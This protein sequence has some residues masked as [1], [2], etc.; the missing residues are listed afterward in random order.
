M[1]LLPIQLI[2]LAILIL[3][4]SIGCAG[5]SS[6]PVTPD[7]TVS[8]ATTSP[9]P[10]N[11]Y[12]WGYWDVSIDPDT[13]QA[14]V[15][16]ARTTDFH[17][18]AVKLLEVWPCKDC[19]S[20][21]N[22]HLIEPHKLSVDVTLRHPYANNLNLTA[23]DVRGI[24][25][26]DADY[27]YFYEFGWGREV[28][29]LTNADG[30]CY[31]F[32]MPINDWLPD[33]LNYYPGD[34]ANSDDLSSE[35]NPFIAYGRSAPRRMFLPGTQETRTME[36][37]FPSAPFEFGY[38]VD[39]CWAPPGKQV[40]DPEVDFPPEANC[41]EPYRIFVR[42][43]EGLDE[44]EQSSAK[45]QVKAYD[46]QGP[47]TISFCD[48]DCDDVSNLIPGT[49]SV[50]LPDDSV[51]FTGSITN[52]MGAEVG[53]YPLMVRVV[54]HNADPNLDKRA[55]FQIVP[56]E[57]HPM[58]Q[59]PPI[60][61]GDA[62]P[63]LRTVGDEIEFFDDGSY[64]P[65]GGSITLWEWD[66]END[67][68]YD[69]E[70]EDIFHAYDTPGEY[71]VM[72][73][74]TDDDGLST[75]LDEPIAITVKT[76]I[77]WVRTWPAYA[78]WDVD[79]DGE[80]NVYVAGYW[81]GASVDFD[82][83]PDEDIHSEPGDFTAFLVKYGKTGIYQ[84]GKS[85]G[86]V[87]YYAQVGADR[88]TVDS[89]GNVFVGG[90]FNYQVDFDPGPGEDIHN[91]NGFLDAYISK[92]NADGDYQWVRILSGDNHDSVH[93]LF[94]DSDGS[95]YVC[96]NFWGQI[97]LDP[98]PGEDI[99]VSNGGTDVYLLKLDSDGSVEWARS[100]GSDVEDPSNPSDS[101]NRISADDSGHVF[102]TGFYA[103]SCDFDP[104]PGEDIHATND[105]HNNYGDAFLSAFDSDGNFMWA[106]TWGGIKGDSS[107]G[108]AV[109][110]DGSIYTTGFFRYTVD[111][112]P[113][114]G[115]DEHTSVEYTDS[116]LSRFSSGGDFFWAG[117]WEG[118]KHE[119]GTALAS[120]GN[121]GI[122]VTGT[123][124]VTTDF[125]PGPGVEE[126]TPASGYSPDMF[127]SKFNTD[128]EFQWVNVW[129]GNGTGDFDQAYGVTC[130]PG[131]EPYVTGTH[132]GTCDFDPGP[133]V[134]ERTVSHALE[135]FLLRFAPD[136]S[137]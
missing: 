9:T 53:I 121:G 124:Y 86:S 49:T 131:G 42:I 134:D 1:R 48:L 98:G 73:R 94:P 85:W 60:A 76:G 135:A 63:K 90:A 110:S 92:F 35:L 66:F 91:S 40:V 41:N 51:L 99:R 19:L 30:Y 46:H 29:R 5:G 39:A 33:I 97:D 6:N 59:Y 103:G 105:D 62:Y 25:I 129:G 79:T 120:D 45:I 65:D 20:I 114:P 70:G 80:G 74:V 95:I 126:R 107:T 130:G 81:T 102:A 109:G 128:C 113:G 54:D 116:F 127:L 72:L 133:G 69:A 36:I 61:A 3:I 112:D 89:Y 17:L 93:C 10:T 56:I 104:G 119:E 7:I 84:W 27:D 118:P 136:G 100:W 47:E 4:L 32:A 67:G 96:G 137:Y 38:A 34:F 22:I 11:R 132:D 77:G 64:D 23:F 57:V 123:Y 106:R 88:I 117:T 52:T 82:P 55:A 71:E 111:F 83:G 43:G 108:I 58:G 37:Y 68:T 75:T 15:I 101:I 31:Y 28:P 14:T 122:Y 115:V 16:P 26:T 18:N 50:V 2:F 125:D 87:G 44:W 8:S 21:S 13:L 24:M 12:L 78:G